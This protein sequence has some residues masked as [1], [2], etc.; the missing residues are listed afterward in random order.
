MAT[1]E[2][3]TRSV[4]GDLKTDTM[5][6]NMGPQH[7]STHGVLRL[8]LVV[9]GEV[10]VDVIPHIGYL[11]RC[12]E[13][14]AEQMTNYQQVIPYVDR[15]DYVAAMGNEL[16]YVLAVEKLLGIEVPERVQYIRVI[17]AELQRIAS[18]LLAIGTYG[19]DLGAFTPFLWCFRER[20]KIL[21]LFEITCGARLL[22]NYIWVGGVSHDLPSEFGKKLKDFFENIPKGTERD[23]RSFD[24]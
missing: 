14:H 16:A 7:P 2:I 24:I 6:L 23:K 17:M 9:D 18:H 8:E 20:E 12:F 13:K 15:M 5:I 22:Y 4:K 10:I 3:T 21:D 19:L 11:H 1:F